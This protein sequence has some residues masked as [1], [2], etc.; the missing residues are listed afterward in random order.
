M[1]W[2]SLNIIN[3]T[4][5]WEIEILPNDVHEALYNIEAIQITRGLSSDTLPIQFDPTEAQIRFRSI[6]EAELPK[7]L[8]GDTFEIR[9][10]TPLGADWVHMS[11]WL[12]NENTS[13]AVPENN[14]LPVTHEITIVGAL[15]AFDKP[16]T[17][18]PGVQWTTAGPEALPPAGP[19]EPGYLGFIEYRRADLQAEAGVPILYPFIEESLDKSLISKWVTATEPLDP[20]GVTLRDLLN[21]LAQTAHVL[22]HFKPAIAADVYSAIPPSAYCETVLDGLPAVKG[23]STYNWNSE[24]RYLDILPQSVLMPVTYAQ[25]EA[26]PTTV[27]YVTST[28]SGDENIELV[29][30]GGNANSAKTISTSTWNTTRDTYWDL[31][32]IEFKNYAK[33]WITGGDARIPSSLELKLDEF[34]LTKLDEL[35]SALWPLKTLRINY[36]SPVFAF[37]TFH[38]PIKTTQFTLAAGEL[39]IV[40]EPFRAQFIDNTIGPIFTDS[41]YTNRTLDSFQFERFSDISLL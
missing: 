2:S 13:I 25:L 21:D 1:T 27:E 16:F 22:Q 38:Y 17:G 23:Y 29:S 30:I 24:D 10:K 18:T 28:S 3:H 37:Q 31:I 9:L 14:S 33:A 32:E 40:V 7:M 20:V 15:S 35:A 12:I 19:G 5:N 6:A 4:Q 39:S 8:R 11:G 26:T 36:L 41:A 34:T